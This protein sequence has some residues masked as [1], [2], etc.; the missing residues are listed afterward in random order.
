MNVGGHSNT[1]VRELDSHFSMQNQIMKSAGHYSKVV[2]GLVQDSG[3]VMLKTS[4]ST[5]ERAKGF[6]SSLG[7]STKE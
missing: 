4:Q 5:M 1:I 2:G 7:K 6:F 3:S